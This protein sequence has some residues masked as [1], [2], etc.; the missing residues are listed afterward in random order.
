[1]KLESRLNDLDSCKKFA[2][3]FYLKYSGKTNAKTNNENS[4][5]LDSKMAQSQNNKDCF[6]S[7]WDMEWLQKH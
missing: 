4:T 6:N 2:L 5:L 3:E 1:M 7:N